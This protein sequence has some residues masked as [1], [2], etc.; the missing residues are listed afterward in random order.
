[1]AVTRESPLVCQ[2]EVLRTCDLRVIFFI[3]AGTNARMWC[4][5]G[6][7]ILPICPLIKTT[8]MFLLQ[9]LVVLALEP[10]TVTLYYGL[11]EANELYLEAEEMFTFT[12]I[13]RNG[14]NYRI[15][16]TGVCIGRVVFRR[17]NLG[18]K[19]CYTQIHICRIF[20]CISF[21]IGTFQ[22]YQR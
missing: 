7:S 9:A 5:A 2:S 20:C 16:S 3:Y 17:Y 18:L 14:A 15:N 12:G 1:M 6:A 11:V 21:G 4:R 10:A 22:I 13:N 8:H 19:G